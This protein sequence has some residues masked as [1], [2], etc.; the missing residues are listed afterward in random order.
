VLGCCAIAANGARRGDRRYITAHC[1]LGLI[2][3]A[4]ERGEFTKR[5]IEITGV[6]SSTGGGTTMRNLLVGELPFGDVGTA[7]VLAAY[8]GANIRMVN[9]SVRTLADLFWVTMPNSGIKSIKDL[10]AKRWASPLRNR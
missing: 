4:L 5:G 9:A 2:A 1:C 10:A 7:A 8:K 6:L 3:V